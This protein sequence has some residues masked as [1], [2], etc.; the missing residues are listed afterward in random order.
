[1][2]CKQDACYYY[3]FACYYYSVAYYFLASEKDAHITIM[4]VLLT[5]FLASE[6][7]AHIPIT[8]FKVKQF[9]RECC[10]Y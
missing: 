3:S 7:D 6:Q 9:T 2:E 5:L 1:M 8:S 10:L 4:L